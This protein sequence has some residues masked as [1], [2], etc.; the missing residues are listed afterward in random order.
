MEFIHPPVGMPG[1]DV[2]AGLR[3]ALAPCV[4]RTSPVEAQPFVN[5]AQSTRETAGT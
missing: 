5:A 2:R 1:I 4:R 3:A